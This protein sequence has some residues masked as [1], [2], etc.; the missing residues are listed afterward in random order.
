MNLFVQVGGR[1]GENSFDPT[2]NLKKS[3]QIINPVTDSGKWVRPRTFQ[4]ILISCIREKLKATTLC[5][6]ITNQ[7]H[8]SF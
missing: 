8:G 6:F 5:L 4:H 3:D 1:N 7:T 2:R